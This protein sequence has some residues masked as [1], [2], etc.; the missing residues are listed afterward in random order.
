MQALDIPPKQADSLL[1]LVEI[2]DK[3]IDKRCGLQHPA[4]WLSGIG[5]HPFVCSR[6]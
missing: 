3:K 5:K 1:L 6:A 4:K 2:W